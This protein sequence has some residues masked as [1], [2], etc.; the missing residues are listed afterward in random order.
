[1]GEFEELL[2]DMGAK[3]WVRNKFVAQLGDWSKQGKRD[4][5]EFINEFNATILR[6]FKIIARE[7]VDETIKRATELTTKAT[8][9]SNDSE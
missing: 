9:V 8:E 6:E 3:Q 1:M 2:G 4:V 7:A 5:D